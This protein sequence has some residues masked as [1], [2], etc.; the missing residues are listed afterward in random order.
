VEPM[1]I[2]ILGLLIAVLM[3]TW[4]TIG[5]LYPLDT[6]ATYEPAWIDCKEALH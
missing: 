6:D 1:T 3:V 4:Y 5:N 2:P